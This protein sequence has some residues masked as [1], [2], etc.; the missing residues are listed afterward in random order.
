MEE[1]C[2][3]AQQDGSKEERAAAKA[4]LAEIIEVGGWVA[5]EPSVG[6]HVVQLVR[7]VWDEAEGD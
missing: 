3:L 7:V 1:L 5:L 6:L 2:I 4:R